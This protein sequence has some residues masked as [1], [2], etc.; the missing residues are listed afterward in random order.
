MNW[1]ICFFN[2]RVQKD[3]QKW[4]VGVY[5]DF[6]RLASLL[7]LYGTDLRLPHSR[8][9]GAGLFELRCHGS[10]GIGRAFYC[11]MRGKRIVILHGFIKKT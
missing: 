3:I 8:A 10:D 11:T 5:A 2:G 1:S 6:L 4:P 7:E 9:M